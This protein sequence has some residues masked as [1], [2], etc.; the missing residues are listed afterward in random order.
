MAGEVRASAAVPKP[1][2]TDVRRGAVG[3]HVV[4]L[5]CEF[6]VEGCTCWGTRQSLDNL[7]IIRSAEAAQGE[8]DALP[9]E[10][11]V[12][13]FYDPGDPR[14]SLL[15]PWAPVSG[16]LGSLFGLLLIAGGLTLV[17]MG[18]HPRRAH[19]Q[20]LENCFIPGVPAVAAGCEHSL[21]DEAWWN[22]QVLTLRRGVMRSFAF[23]DT[24]GAPR[25]RASVHQ[26][27]YGRLASVR[28][29]AFATAVR[30]NGASPLSAVAIA[31]CCSW[32][33]MDAKVIFFPSH[34]IHTA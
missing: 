7:G 34:G 16:V 28:R 25:R 6:N 31:A 24:S 11:F 2:I 21:S 30:W 14:I 1:I 19:H 17:A 32:P 5:Q 23:L 18:A 15:E 9:K 3:T 26:T 10:R 27:H 4:V 29:L 20:G 22:A 13:V 33:V 12:R 8:A